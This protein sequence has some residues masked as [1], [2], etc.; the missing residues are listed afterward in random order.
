MA[1]EFGEGEGLEECREVEGLDFFSKFESDF[2]LGEEKSK[3]DKEGMDGIKSP[4]GYLLLD[5]CPKLNLETNKF[6]GSEI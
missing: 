1:A 3:S 5:S 4:L 2:F 6:S